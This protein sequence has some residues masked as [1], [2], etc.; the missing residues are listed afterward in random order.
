MSPK[1]LLYTTAGILTG[2][3]LGTIGLYLLNKEQ[4]ASEQ[5]LVP[6]VQTQTYT[7]TDPTEK[8]GSKPPVVFK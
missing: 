3:F 5:P 4:I 7:P 1:S 2:G 8:T 6:S